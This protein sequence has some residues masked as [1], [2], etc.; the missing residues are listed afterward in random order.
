MQYK[1]SIKSC[2]FKSKQVRQESEKL[3]EYFKLSKMLN[4]QHILE[5]DLGRIADFMKAFP[6]FQGNFQFINPSQYRN[7]FEKMKMRLCERA[8]ILFK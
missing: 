4:V 7:C 3:G 5:R 8:T 1:K 6:V 2:Q